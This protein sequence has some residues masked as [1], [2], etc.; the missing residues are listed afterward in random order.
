MVVAE[1]AEEG[2]RLAR[3][4]ISPIDEPRRQGMIAVQRTLGKPQQGKVHV[5]DEL[6]WLE[7]VQAGPS[8]WPIWRP[9][10]QCVGL[11]VDEH[12]QVELGDHLPVV[13]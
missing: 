8:E 1:A 7:V 4:G 2:G 5:R 10:G 11:E 6:E 12:V 9:D 13:S 3:G